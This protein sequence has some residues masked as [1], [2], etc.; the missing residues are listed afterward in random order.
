MKIDV[1]PL[2]RRI[3]DDPLRLV[4]QWLDIPPL[5]FSIDY[6]FTV[7]ISP[8]Q[9]TAIIPFL[10]RSSD[11]L[12]RNRVRRN[13]QANQRNRRIVADSSFNNSHSLPAFSRKSFRLLYIEFIETSATGNHSSSPMISKCNA[14]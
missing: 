12:F 13:I 2:D 10:L 6:E 9:S 14:Q 1:G 8:P 3:D 5:F 4:G 7:S 11:T